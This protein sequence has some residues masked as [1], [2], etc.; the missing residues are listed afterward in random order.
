MSLRDTVESIIRQYPEKL[1]AG[2]LTQLN[3]FTFDVE[4]VLARAGKGARVCDIGGGWGTFALACAAAGMKP[5]LV[6][7]FRDHGFFEEEVMDAMRRLYDKYGVEVVSRDVVATQIDFPERSFDAITTFDSLEHWH[8]SPKR[9]LARVAKTLRSGGLF[10]L[11]TPNCVNLRK[12]ITVPLGRGK[13]TAMEDWYEQEVFRGHVRE[14]DVDDL[15][16][17]AR[18]MKLAQYEIIG[19]NWMGYDARSPLVRTLA[20]FAD[21]L[22]R[23]RPTLC[24]DLY[25]VGT[26]A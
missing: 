11:A 20:P 2:Q 4:L 1:V 9:L 26:V 17:M 19:R 24:S 13:W 14:P 7:D 10:V 8:A 15:R 21:R 22:L 16:Y 3:R 6:D 18:D 25:L 23:L 12:R 5:V